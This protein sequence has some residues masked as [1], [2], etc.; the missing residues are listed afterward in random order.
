MFLLNLV[1]HFFVI[2]AW[3]FIRAN[4]LF[5]NRNNQVIFSVYSAEKEKV[6]LCYC[7]ANI[8]CWKDEV[9]KF[10]LVN[11]TLPFNIFIQSLE[12]RG[13]NRGTTLSISEPLFSGMIWQIYDWSRWIIWEKVIALRW[14]VGDR[15]SFYPF[16]QKV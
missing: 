15:P 11:F 7:Y 13:D 16:T 3:V 6:W 12:E 4:K 14:R 5:I 2:S 9:N 1:L 8:K 10:G